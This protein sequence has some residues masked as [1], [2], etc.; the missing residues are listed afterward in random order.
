[1]A[2]W[3][4]GSGTAGSLA[5]ARSGRSPAARHSIAPMQA[6]VLADGDVARPCRGST[7]RGRAGPTPPRSSSPPTAARATPT[8]LGL[9]VDHLGRRRRLVEPRRPRRARGRRR[10]D[11]AG[12]RPTRTSRTPSW[13][14]SRRSTRGADDVVDP[15]GARRRAHRPRARQRRPARP[16]AARRPR[17]VLLDAGAR[18]ALVR[19]P[20]AG[21]PPVRR[22]LPGRDRR[23]RLAA[24]ARATASRASRRRPALPAAPTSRCR[25]DRRAACRTSATRRGAASTVRRGPLLVVETPATLST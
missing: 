14:S 22:A 4:S 15:R 20:G 12:R 11:P 13:P 21:R 25:P 5:S 10:P 19:A 17:A 3:S 1:M 8:P 7:R 2:G 9:A 16:S 6:I 23:P 18:I 24:A